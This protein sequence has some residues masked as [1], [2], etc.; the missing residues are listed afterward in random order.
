[1]RL[2]LIL[3]RVEPTMMTLPSICPY[4]NCEGKHFTLHQ[5]VDKV[6]RD[7]IYRDIVAHS[8][9]CLRCQHTF[10]EYPQ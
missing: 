7:K 10:Q 3:P 2:R 1:M 5:K 8:Y 4:E 6:I 9:E